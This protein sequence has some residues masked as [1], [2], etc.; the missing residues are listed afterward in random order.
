MRFAVDAHAIGRNLTGNEVYVRNLL[1][2][3][4]GLDPGSEFFAYVSVESAR[5][6]IPEGFSCRQVAR[7]PFL[8]LGLDLSRKLRQDRPDLLH[9]QYTAPLGCPVPVVASVHDVSFLEHPEYFPRM[10][11]LQL[12]WTVRRTVR[13]AA[14]ILTPSTF[15]RDAIA[16]AYGLDPERITVVPNAVST[17][18]RPMAREQ[19]A[20]QV[21]A[22][23]GIAAPYV[24][25]VGDVQ[26]RKNQEGLIRAFAELLRF[27]PE[28]PHHLVLVGQESWHGWR[29]R[30][31]AKRS[32]VAERI[33]FT[34]F[35]SD[36]ELLALY[37][38]CDLFV[39]PSHYE[40]FGLP[41]L[42]AMACGRAVACS[43]TTAMPEVADAAAL[44][45]DPR[46]TEQIV[47]A[48]RD[49]LMDAQLRGRLERL[50]LQ[51][52]SQFSW[53]KTAEQTLQVYQEVV[54]L[55]DSAASL[56]PRTLTVS[57]R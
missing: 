31:A 36:E 42:E 19:A 2:S 47:L 21:K 55:R 25:T 29:A 32:A 56:A 16:R 26:A 6:S 8:R 30:R 51:R 3:L 5:D 15:S 23:F 38:G 1:N 28:L 7:G 40:G 35:V 10:R 54:A 50:G 34:G 37:G 12:R 52:A 53:K 9:V 17:S 44:L 46:S 24:L 45:F 43:N 18:F 39:F 22:R 11:S 4:A 48:M 14:R 41:I 57:R 27:Y 20:S 13:R 49:V 33:H